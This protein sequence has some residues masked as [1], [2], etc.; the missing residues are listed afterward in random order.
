MQYIGISQEAWALP[1]HFFEQYY[2]NK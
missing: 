1:P 2:T